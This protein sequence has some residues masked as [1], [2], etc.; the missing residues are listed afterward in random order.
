MT[1][2][3]AA[4]VVVCLIAVPS[5]AVPVD[6]VRE[7]VPSTEPAVPTYEELRDLSVR[8][9]A[10]QVRELPAAVQSDLWTKHLLT[11]LAE[12]PEFTEVQRAVIQEALSLLTPQLFAIEPSDPRRAELVDQPLDRLRIRARAAFDSRVARELFTQMGPAVRNVEYKP[13]SSRMIWGGQPKLPRWTRLPVGSNN[14]PTCEC[15]VLSDWCS[16]WSGLGRIFCGQT[17]G[18]YFTSS[19]CG[20]LFRYACNGMCRE[21]PT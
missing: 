12:H 20:A 2:L 7:P 17:G 11:S 21:R 19:G 15:S 10:A 13:P 5:S 8:E 16:D 1:R 18:C 14:Y 3:V 4:F 9:R 6:G